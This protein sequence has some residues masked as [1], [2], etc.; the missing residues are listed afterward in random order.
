[1][2]ADGVVETNRSALHLL[3]QERRRGE[4]L[5]KRCEVEDR[6]FGGRRRIGLEAQPPE[7]L[8]PQRSGRVAYLDCRGG[9]GL[10]GYRVLNHTR[11]CVER[12]VLGLLHQLNLLNP[13]RSGPPSKGKRREPYERGEAASAAPC[14]MPRNRGSMSS[15]IASRIEPCALRRRDS[16]FG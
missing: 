13:H 14:S 12:D 8:P 15:P 10:L 2:S 11:G 9:K 7:R 4:H 5:G 3:H 6:V 1:M 16:A